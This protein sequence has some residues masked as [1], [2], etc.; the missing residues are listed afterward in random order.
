M[1]TQT[2]ESQQALTPAK[3]LQL[4]IDGNDRFQKSVKSERNLMEQVKATGGGQFPIA[5]VLHCIDSRV[6]AELLFDQGVGDIFSARVAGNFVNEDILGSM[7]FACKVAGSKL[8][9][10][11]GHSKCGAVKGA[12]D[13]VELGNLTAMLSKLQPAVDKVSAISGKKDSSDSQF[14]ADV[15]EANV[16]LTIEN[17]KNDSPV[18][19]EMLQ[20]SEI[21]IV[22]GMYDVGSGKVKFY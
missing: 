18:L 19:N 17:I 11:L 12:C 20:N 6:S 4:L 14:V 5:I 13:G 22:G 16:H 1:N 2:K 7:E 3:A 15:S 21:D 9:V 10:V 8:V